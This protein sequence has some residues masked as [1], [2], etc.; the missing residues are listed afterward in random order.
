MPQPGNP[1]SLNRYSYCLNNPV[2]YT[3][4]TGKWIVEEGPRDQVFNI[5]GIGRVGAVFE[6]PY[7]SELRKA[8]LKT[9]ADILA[10]RVREHLEAVVRGERAESEGTTSAE[11]MM[12]VVNHG[13]RLSRNNT[14]VF[15]E[16]VNAVL[17]GHTVD[18]PTYVKNQE[19]DDPGLNPYYVEIPGS[20]GFREPFRDPDPENPQTHHLWFYI[21]LSYETDSSVALLTN[22]YHEF[23]PSQSGRSIEDFRCGLAGQRLGHLATH[24]FSPTDIADWL[25]DMVD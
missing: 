21:Q 7:A 25:Y 8:A 17:S 10:P 4:P 12:A 14:A 15:M 5:Q 18:L 6:S 1:Q 11:A 20:L 3:D 13:V 2:R 24:W 19:P 22:A 9:T 23:Y 16:G